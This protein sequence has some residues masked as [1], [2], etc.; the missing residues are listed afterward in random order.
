M[1]ADDDATEPLELDL[2]LLP[3]MRL[4]EGQTELTPE[5]AANYQQ[6][7]QVL[8][9]IRWLPNVRL[10]FQVLGISIADIK[11][12]I[13]EQWHKVYQEEPS[14]E[15][16]AHPQVLRL[17]NFALEKLSATL[18]A[19]RSPDERKEAQ[20]KAREALKEQAKRQRTK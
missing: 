16:T 15:D 5:A 10:T 3:D 1:H 4:P 12:L 7:Y 6:A 20:K 8:Q 19:N 9:Q 11:A 17:L 18:L 2:D 13:G 14:P